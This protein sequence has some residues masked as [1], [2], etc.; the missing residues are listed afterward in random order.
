MAPADAPRPPDSLIVRA[1]TWV[2]FPFVLTWMTIKSALAALRR[3]AARLLALAR[4]AAQALAAAARRVGDA[5]R[6]TLATMA[7]G[8]RRIGS[9]LLLLARG[10]AELLTRPLRLALAALRRLAPACS[11]WPVA[12]PRPS[13]PRRAGRATRCASRWPRWPT[14][15][16]ASAA[17]CCCSRAASPSC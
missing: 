11:R 7:D 6:I 8:L 5:M 2:A 9:R 10:L 13:P 17:A 4:G 14:A 15:C 16:V 3:L 1:L 12:R